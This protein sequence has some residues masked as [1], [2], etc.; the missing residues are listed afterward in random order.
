MFIISKFVARKTITRPEYGMKMFTFGKC[1][2]NCRNEFDRHL[3][4]LGGIRRQFSDLVADARRRV[5]LAGPV[6]LLLG[7]GL[8]GLR[9]LRSL[10]QTVFRGVVT[11]HPQPPN[12]NGCFFS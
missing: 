2:H 10:L 5:S 1:L 4:H 8:L 7:H 3:L 9:R 12:P 11:A 6:S